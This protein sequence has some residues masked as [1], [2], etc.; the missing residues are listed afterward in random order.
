M[1]KER[2]SVN[3]FVKGEPVERGV[4]VGKKE[5]W[6]R[7]RKIE[8]AAEKICDQPDGVTVFLTSMDGQDTYGFFTWDESKN[9]Y[10]WYELG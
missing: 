5:D 4:R 3:W 6:E 1:P 7:V 9:E 8:L 10:D 2:I